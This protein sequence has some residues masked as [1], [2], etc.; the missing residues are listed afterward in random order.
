MLTM[1]K[2]QYSNARNIKCKT[3]WLLKVHNSSITESKDIEILEMPK[4]SS[5]SSFK[6]D[7]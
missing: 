7:Q 1:C 3:T 5:K 2:S 6:N 4:M